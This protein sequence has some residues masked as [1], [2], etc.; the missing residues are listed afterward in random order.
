M[1]AKNLLVVSACDY[2]VTIMGLSKSKVHHLMGTLLQQGKCEIFVSLLQQQIALGLVSVQL[3]DCSVVAVQQLF[4]MSNQNGVKCCLL[5]GKIVLGTNTGNAIKALLTRSHRSCVRWHKA[6]LAVQRRFWICLLKN[7]VQL[8]ELQKAV[9]AI[10][11]A[12]EKA[13]TLYKRYVRLMVLQQL[14]YTFLKAVYLFLPC[15][16]LQSL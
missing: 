16:G 3:L 2:H 6:A 1:W 9:K 12:E 13:G 15:L 7:T 8:A 11:T 10:K 14:P 5:L 4:M